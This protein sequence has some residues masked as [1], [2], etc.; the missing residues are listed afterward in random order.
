MVLHHV[1]GM[2]VGEVAGEIGAPVETV[3]SRL[4]IGKQKLRALH[5]REAAGG[6]R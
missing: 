3:R 6:R 5:E 4:R 2:T 1:V